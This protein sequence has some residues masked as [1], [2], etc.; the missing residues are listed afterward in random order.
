MRIIT[1][2]YLI[3]YYGRKSVLGAHVAIVAFYEHYY[4]QSY[5]ILKFPRIRL[6]HNILVLTIIFRQRISNF[7]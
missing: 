3:F 1:R 7:S 6:T 4:L 5:E 2:D